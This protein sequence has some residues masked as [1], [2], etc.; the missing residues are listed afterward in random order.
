MFADERTL[1]MPEL[2]Q[3]ST[4]VAAAEK[5]PFQAWRYLYRLP[6]LLLLGVIGLPILLAALLPGIRDLNVH[7]RGLGYRVQQRYARL[8]L[9]VLGVRLKIRGSLPAAPYLLVANHISWFDIPLLHALEPMWL[10]AKDGIRSWP[11]V[12]FVARAVGTVFIERGAESSRKQVARRMAALLKREQPIGIFPEAGISSKRG[13]G[14][15]HARLLAPAVRVGVPIV[16]VAIRYYRNGDVHAERVFGPGS[17]LL[18]LMLSMMARPPCEGQIMIAPALQTVGDDGHP[19]SRSDLA[20]Q[21]EAAV[22]SM[23]DHAFD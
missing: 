12:G 15:F 18:S 20:R 22:R 2:T 4:P 9:W 8:L 17:N 19:V 5:G 1:Q 14:R 13:V 11:L 3:L 23:Y 21:A 16:P 10:I 7:G 6:M